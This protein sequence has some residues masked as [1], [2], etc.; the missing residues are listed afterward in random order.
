MLGNIVLIFVVAPG[1]SVLPEQG[2]AADLEIKAYAH[3]ILEHGVHLTGTL[4]SVP[5]LVRTRS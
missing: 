2:V 4:D 3:D 1:V 5:K